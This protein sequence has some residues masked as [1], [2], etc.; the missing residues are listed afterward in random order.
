MNARHLTW[1]MARLLVVDDSFDS[2]WSL[3]IALRSL[4][5]EVRITDNS[6][7]ALELVGVSKPDIVFID[8]FM[9]ELSGFDIARQLRE[10]H[11]PQGLCLIAVTGYPGDAH[12]QRALE[13]GFNLHLLKPVDPLVLPAVLGDCAP[14]RKRPEDDGP[15]P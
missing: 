10:E 14:W 2:A 4:G 15:T 11:G 6:S 3:S 7:T 1:N 9:P 12:R 5:H 8:L 13:A